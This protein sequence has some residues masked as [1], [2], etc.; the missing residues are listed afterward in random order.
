MLYLH[1][2]STQINSGCANGVPLSQHVVNRDILGF[3]N[4]VTPPVEPPLQEELISRASSLSTR[5]MSPLQ[6][7]RAFDPVIAEAVHRV[8]TSFC[9]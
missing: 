9:Q 7:I 8:M 3:F 2:D 5:K 1:N 6:A 4:D